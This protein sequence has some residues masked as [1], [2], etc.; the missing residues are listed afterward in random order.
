MRTH[1]YMRI[2]EIHI[3]IRNAELN[4]ENEVLRSQIEESKIALDKVK[5]QETKRFV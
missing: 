4:E 1:A 2:Y 5:V 3:L